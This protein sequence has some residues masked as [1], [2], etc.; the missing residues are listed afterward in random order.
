MRH[1]ETG[2]ELES[3][4]CMTNY[5]DFVNFDS[6]ASIPRPQTAADELSH[7]ERVLRKSDLRGNSMWMQGL[8]KNFKFTPEDHAKQ[9]V[10]RD[11]RKWRESH[12]GLREALVDTMSNPGVR[13]SVPVAMNRAAHEFLT[14]PQTGP[15]R[16]DIER[17]KEGERVLRE[18][19][20]PK[21][22]K[23]YRNMFH[24]TLWHPVTVIDT[25][26]GPFKAAEMA[27]RDYEKVCLEIQR[28]TRAVTAHNRR[29][30]Y[31]LWPP[32]EPKKHVDTPHG[33]NRKRDYIG[34]A[35]PL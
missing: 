31:P 25:R 24:S 9:E 35:C 26:K 7:Y 1:L 19:E 10:F 17:Y 32:R 21:M 30:R 2:F 15:A 3:I 4:L 12:P 23:E 33:L 16:P 22:M 5:F 29:A 13:V 14:R 8:Q 6:D 34:G 28:E 11:A 27:R 20:R 18:G